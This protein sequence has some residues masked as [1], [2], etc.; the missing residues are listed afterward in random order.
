MKSNILKKQKYKEENEIY[1]MI[2]LDEKKDNEEKKH[3]NI[4]IQG[5]TYL[6]EP[7]EDDYLK[8]QLPIS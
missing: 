2:N 5:K 6:K 1:N 4:I 3:N 8:I 7:T